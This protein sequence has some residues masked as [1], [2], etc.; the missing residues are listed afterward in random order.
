MN[1]P[2][3]PIEPFK[4]EFLKVSD[5][6]TL[7][8][9]QSGNPNGKPVIV[10]HGGPG[11][12]SKPYHRQYFDPEKYRVIMF[13]QRGCGKSNPQ[14][15]VKEN[16]IQDLVDDIEK[17]RKN[18]SIDKW[19]V[20][21]GSWGSTL[22]LAYT[23]AH[24]EFIK[25]IILYGIFL[26]S[27]EELSWNANIFWPEIWE[28]YSQKMN[29]QNEQESDQK[30]IDLFE[31]NDINELKK[32]V[33][34]H[35]AWKNHTY[36]LEPVMEVTQ[37]A[38]EEEINAARILSHYIKNNGFLKPD[39]LLVEA[40]K[41]AHI[42]TAIIQGRYDMCCPPIS[43]WKLHKKLPES[44]IDFVIAGH[45]ASEPAITD[46]IIEYSNKFSSL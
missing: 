11:S 1:T 39:Q 37:E 33:A 8:L 13:D 17:I 23:Q 18:L 30:I 9:E 28:E 36:D 25:A 26:F 22:A 3:P 34:A 12:R 46:K 19:V 5:I 38:T 24:T 14:G 6:H 15:E 4:I 2:F 20:S 16:T 45:R 44:S 35:S 43:A 29:V 10:L 41:I 42:P 31:K 21:G 40:N 32:A 7:Y 27:D